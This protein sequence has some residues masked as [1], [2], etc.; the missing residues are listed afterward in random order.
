MVLAAQA[1]PAVAALD[2]GACGRGEV[3]VPEEVRRVV[4]FMR[5][6]CLVSRSPS[7]SL[8][9]R[10]FAFLRWGERN[11]LVPVVATDRRFF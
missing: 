11:R 3:E 6:W 7:L 4:A 5:I 10:P 2:F 1:L 9:L 8:F